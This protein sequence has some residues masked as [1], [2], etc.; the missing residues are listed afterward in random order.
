MGNVYV[1][2]DF[3]HNFAKKHLS[4]LSVSGLSLLYNYFSDIFACDA[5]PFWTSFLDE[6]AAFGIS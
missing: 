4:C 3:L 5:F 6:H 1:K 2:Q